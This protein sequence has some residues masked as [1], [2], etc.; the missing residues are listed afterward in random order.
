MYNSMTAEKFIEKYQFRKRY[1]SDKSG[2]F[3]EKKVKAILGHYIFV[4]DT[5]GYSGIMYE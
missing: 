4:I 3:Y 1:L 5:E 2:H